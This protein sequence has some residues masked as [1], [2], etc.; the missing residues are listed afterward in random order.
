MIACQPSSTAADSG[1]ENSRYSWNAEEDKECKLYQRQRLEVLGGLA[2]GIA[3]DF[4]NFLAVIMVTLGVAEV[5][6]GDPAA[7]RRRLADAHK[8]CKRAAELVRQLLAFGRQQQ[9]ER[10]PTRLQPV[11]GEA[12]R[13]VQSSI[14]S[15]VVIDAQIDP[16]APLVLANACQIHQVLLNLSINAAHAMRKR[17]ARLTIRLDTVALDQSQSAEIPNLDPGRYVRLVVRD[18]G[19]GMN[20]DTLKR[21]FEPSFT[22]KPPGEGSGLGLAIVQN[23]VKDHGGAIEVESAEGIGTTFTVYFP[24]CREEPRVAGHPGAAI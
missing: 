21:I 8:E 23:I 6:A 1:S 4:N 17:D 7:V 18:T 10:L 14:P 13:M 22:T 2:S 5:E 11:I 19:H 9:P 15:E 16:L 3:H 20:R 12:V 24:V